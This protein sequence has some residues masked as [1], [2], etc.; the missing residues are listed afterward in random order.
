MV[1]FLRIGLTMAAFAVVVMCGMAAGAG[2]AN[3]APYAAIVMDMRDGEVIHSRSADRRQHPASLTKMMTLYLTFEAITT[4]Q[5]GL[6]QKV[7]ISRHAARQPP[8]K[9]GM[10]AGQRVSVRHL[11]RA[12][13]IRS[14]N[15]AAMA[16]AEAVGGSE[17]AFAR[18]MTEK[19]RAL[20]MRSTTFKNP[21]GLTQSGHLSTAR[22]MALLARHLYFD[23]PQYYN[24]F[25]RKVAYA[26]GKQV[27]TTNR[28]LRS[29]RGAE[30]LKTG[31]TRAAGYNLAATAKRNQRRVLVVVMGGKSSAW[32]NKRVA[33]LLDR[34]FRELP[35]RVAEVAPAK[36]GVRVASAPPPPPRP[37]V[38]ATGLAAVSAALMQPAVA[39]VPDPASLS[40]HAPHY[41]ELP[42]QRPGSQSASTTRKAGR[43]GPSR[44]ASA[45]SEAGDWAVQLG[46]FRSQASAVASLNAVSLAEFPMLASAR[47]AIDQGRTKSGKPLY[48]VRYRGLDESGARAACKAVKS[49]GGDCM[50]M[51]PR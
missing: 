21:H 44:A 10:R 37:G 39:A 13:A 50:A 31:Y 36:A 16:L 45:P 42:P 40:P 32:R 24:V 2:Q 17:A 9:L 29:Y 35:A 30:G 3:A 26:A 47:S 1:G 12:A 28:L 22:D 34:G 49:S 19:A 51:A 23:F 14:A 20:G 38:P 6:D 43:N 15:D 46:V 7:R 33:Q 25:G 48:K 27:Y 8:S 11:I 4:G 18:L 41:V 5:L